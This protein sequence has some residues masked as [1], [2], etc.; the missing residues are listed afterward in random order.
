MRFAQRKDAMLNVTITVPAAIIE[1]N[2]ARF[3]VAL[4]PAE[5]LAL[6]TQSDDANSRAFNELV[7]PV[8]SVRTQGTVEHY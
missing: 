5:D 8:T 4:R 2:E 6:L 1:G 3:E 7:S